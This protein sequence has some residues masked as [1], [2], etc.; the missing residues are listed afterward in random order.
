MNLNNNNILAYQGKAN[1]KK[2]EGG[3]GTIG[4]LGSLFLCTVIL[5]VVFIMGTKLAQRILS[6]Y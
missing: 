3:V 4:L 6:L 1:N 5:V 2:E